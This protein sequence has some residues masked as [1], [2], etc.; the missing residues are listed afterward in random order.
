MSFA[1]D[2]LYEPLVDGLSSLA[3]IRQ[4]D[5]GWRVATHCMYPSNG[6]VE[7]T[8]R[9][10]IDTAVVSDEGGA[11]GE[12]LSAGIPVRDYRRNV[13]HLISE[14]GLHLTDGVICTPQV[15]IN[16]IPIS[17][18]LVANASQ[19]V[20]RWLY[21]HTKVPRPR[22]FR[23]L[24]ADYLKRR[25]D[26]RLLKNTVIVG[27]SNKPHRFANVVALANGRRLIIDPVTHDSSSINARVVANLDV[28]AANEPGLEQRIVYDDE[29]NWSPAEL[30]LLG[31]GATVVPFSR[32]QEVIERVAAVA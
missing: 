32:S 12:A 9:G 21:D 1:P 7:V 6:L 31:V 13:S 27:Q 28:R 11:F 30:N 5:G 14:Q 8:V 3:A 29:E 23:L 26:D 15:P 18:L 24:L 10:G 19:D 20:A 4:I 22:D 25:F 17:V 2:H 16:A